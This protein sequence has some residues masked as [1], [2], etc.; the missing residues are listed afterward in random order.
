MN[1]KTPSKQTEEGFFAAAK[2]QSAY[3]QKMEESLK[4]NQVKNKIP[5]TQS[6]E[7]GFY[8]QQDQGMSR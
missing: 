6:Y 3:Q 1:T 4:R 2:Q 8:N 5:S 7:K